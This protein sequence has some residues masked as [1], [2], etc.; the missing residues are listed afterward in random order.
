MFYWS[1]YVSYQKSIHLKEQCIDSYVDP[2]RILGSEK[3]RNYAIIEGGACDAL[4]STALPGGPEG[5]SKR[6]KYSHCWPFL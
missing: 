3:G 1:C 2:C 5:R 4:Q 6:L